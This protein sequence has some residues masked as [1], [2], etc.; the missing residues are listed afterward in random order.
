MFTSTSP[1][2][3]PT[4]PLADLLSQ[5]SGGVSWWMLGVVFL[6]GLGMAIAAAFGK[7]WP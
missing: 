5:L 7:W 2:P 4:T 3:L 6:V 1:T